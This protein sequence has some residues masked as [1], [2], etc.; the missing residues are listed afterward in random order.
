VLELIVPE[1]RENALLDL[2]KVGVP[3]FRGRAELGQIAE[4][5]VF[6]EGEEAT[7]VRSVGLE[8]WVSVFGES[9]VVRKNFFLGGSPF[10]LWC[11]N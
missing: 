11:P 5:S 8:P 6:C 3:P 4:F 1:Q 9:C 7:H 10:S 2:S